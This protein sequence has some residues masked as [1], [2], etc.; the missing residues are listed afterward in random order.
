M[1]SGD[2]GG[3][4]CTMK[5]GL[6]EIF[7]K[8]YRPEDLGREALTLREAAKI[9]GASVGMPQIVGTP[10]QVADQLEILIEETGGDGFNITPTYTPGSFD[11]FVDLVVPLL[12]KRGVHRKEYT[13]RTLREHL[14][15]CSC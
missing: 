10:E 8:M 13:G 15:Q 6:L 12:Q 14:L 3:R 9:Y 5:K 11:E 2:F 7:T 4:T 1:R